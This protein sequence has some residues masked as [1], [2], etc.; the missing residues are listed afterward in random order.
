MPRID[1]LP[2]K[3]ESKQSEKNRKRNI[4]GEKGLKACKKMA[5]TLILYKKEERVRA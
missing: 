5:E 3:F 2:D 4:V 1:Y